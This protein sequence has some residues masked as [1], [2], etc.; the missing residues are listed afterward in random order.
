MSTTHT[1]PHPGHAHGGLSPLLMWLMTGA[2]G[3]AVAGNYYAQPLLPEI[4]RELGIR[5]ASAGSIITTAQLGYALGL[6]LIVPL[7]DML[8]RRRL[9]LLMMSLASGGL[10]I[11][12]TATSISQLLLGTAIAGVCSVVAQILLPLGASLASEAERGRVVGTIMSGLLTGILLA[13]TVAGSLADLGGWHTVYWCGTGGMLLMTLVLAR[14]LPHT[15]ATPGL[16]YGALLQSVLRLFAEEPTLRLR[17]LLGAMSFATFSVMW[18]SV[19]FLLSAPPFGFSNSTIG[20]FGLAGAA[21]ALSANIVGRLSD[22]GHGALASRLSLGLMLL[23]WLPLALA[24][25]S[26][27]ALLLGI[28]LLDL[29]VAGC[30]VSNQGAIYRIRPEARNRLT[31]AYMTSYFIGGAA[32]SLASAWAYGHWGWTGVVL[33]GAACSLTGVCAWALSGPRHHGLAG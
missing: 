7:G 2:T 17:G 13:R 1:L 21:G 14:Q 30:H 26:I 6:L 32:G 19:A 23:A 27:T 3:L 25:H 11:S 28:L 4:S 12:A 8:E 9:I 5:A 20:L 31:S 29:G 16:R 10:L 22:K 33:T 18:T 24:P 15:P